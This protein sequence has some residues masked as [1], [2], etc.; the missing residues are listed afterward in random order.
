MFLYTLRIR[1]DSFLLKDYTS[2]FP[3]CPDQAAPGARDYGVVVFSHITS[4]LH[5]ILCSSI[6]GIHTDG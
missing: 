5:P 6:F 2:Q 4:G 3:L 1:N